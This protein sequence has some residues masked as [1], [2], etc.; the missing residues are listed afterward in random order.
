ML[1]DIIQ[2][3]KIEQMQRNVDAAKK[4]SR[5]AVDKSQDY[6]E[7]VGQLALATQAVWSFLKEK[8]HLDEKDL[9]QRMEELDLMD[10]QKDG[11]VA[12]KV[13]T[14]PSCSRKMNSRNMQCMFCGCGNPEFNPFAE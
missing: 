8:H 5:D 10:G 4:D 1:W 3:W 11:R 13:V 14:C 2:Q 12:P 7:K 6:A 9:M